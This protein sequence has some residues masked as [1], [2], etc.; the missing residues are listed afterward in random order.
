MKGGG[1]T[2]G[3][4]RSPEASAGPLGRWETMA[5]EKQRELGY[6]VY[7]TGLQKG[8]RKGRREEGEGGGEE[9]QKLHLQKK[10]R[11]KERNTHAQA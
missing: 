5:G 8:E 2:K 3:S 7:F 1:P 4:S 10:N 9:R 6:S 11:Q